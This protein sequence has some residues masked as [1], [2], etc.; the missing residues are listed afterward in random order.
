MPRKPPP[1]TKGRHPYPNKTERREY[2][3][4]E[5]TRACT[6]LGEGY[7]YHDVAV[8]TGIPHSSLQQ[9]HRKAVHNFISF[10]I[11]MTDS[12]VYKT[13]PGRGAPKKLTTEE[14]DAICD[15]IVGAADSRKMT[16]PV[17]IK[18]LDL[19]ISESLL[20]QIMYDW[21]YHR[22]SSGWKTELT[23]EQKAKWLQFAHN[24]K[25]KI[26]WKRRA[27]SSDEAKIK[28]AEHYSEKT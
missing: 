17:I 1:R 13:T 4:V 20:N 21:G 11:L 26:D 22:G 12:E 18:D 7:S 19:D 9:L 25:G 5:K 27:I 10:Q 24:H 14:E 15:Y 28:K 8:R 3:N 2:S 6:L 16:T 23:E